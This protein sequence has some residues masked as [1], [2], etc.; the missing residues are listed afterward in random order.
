MDLLNVESVRGE[1]SNRA[2]VL[3]KELKR[4]YLAGASVEVLPGVS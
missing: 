2:I 3:E 4:T 1:V